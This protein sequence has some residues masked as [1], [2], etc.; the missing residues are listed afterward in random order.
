MNFL[1]RIKSKFDSFYALSKLSKDPENFKYKQLLGDSSD[2]LT[3]E[4]I[5]TGEVPD[6]FVEYPELEEQWQAGYNPEKYDINKLSSLPKN[7]LGYQF[8]EHMSRYDFEAVDDNHITPRDKYHWL[9]MRILETHEI[10]HVI[11]GIESDGAGDVACQGVYFSQY[12][13]GQSAMVLSGSVLKNLFTDNI[14]NSQKMID[15]FVKGY[16]LGKKCKPL[17]PVKWEEHFQDDIDELRRE[18][19]IDVISYE[20]L[21]NMH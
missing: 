7:T 21:E 15:C 13:N 6:P 2:T 18:L 19:N 8:A 3:K 16:V 14:G 17:L 12:V 11:I 20:R 9:R 10:W 4:A 5:D 1:Q